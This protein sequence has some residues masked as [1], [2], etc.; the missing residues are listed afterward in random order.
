MAMSLHA[1][2]F[3]IASRTHRMKPLLVL[4]T[5]ASMLSVHPQDRNTPE[6]SPK[7]SKDLAIRGIVLEVGTDHGVPEAEVRLL[8]DSGILGVANEPVSMTNTDAHGR[9]NLQPSEFGTYLVAAQKDGYSPAEG[10]PG[11]IPPTSFV[12]VTLDKYRPKREVTVSLGRPGELTGRIVDDETDKPLTKFR[13]WICQRFYLNGQ[14]REHNYNWSTFT[15]AN[16]RFRFVGLRPSEYLVAISPRHRVIATI[17][18]KDVDAVDSEYERSYWPGGHDLISG[19]P[20]RVPSG[21]SVDVGT[22]R[23]RKTSAYRVRV[24][25]SAGECKPGETLEI[26]EIG[27]SAPETLEEAPC[28]KVFQLAGFQPGSHL[29]ALSITGRPPE[30]AVRGVAE[31]EVTDR[32]LDAQVP[33]ERGADVNGRIVAADTRTVLPFEGMR[34]TIKAVLT[35]QETAVSVGAQGSFRV[36]DAP[37]GVNRAAVTG[38]NPRFYVKQVRINGAAVVDNVFSLAAPASMEIEVD[39][40]AG[41]ITGSVSDA[42]GHAVNQPYVLLVPSSA[43]AANIFDSV[44][45]TTG[46]TSGRFQFAG[47][48][49][50]GYRVLA[51]SLA[52][53]DK[54]DEPHVLD[55]LLGSAETIAVGPTGYQNLSLKLTEPLQ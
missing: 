23:L 29:L 16:G 13:V 37:P 21:D 45:R 36:V 15:D 5:L 22:L 47:L 40:K 14:L 6:A 38:L 17:S 18:D 25:T 26:S 3:W 51:V 42:D 52:S 8:R 43:N 12:V 50:A 48:A 10:K 54:L 4:L 9:F 30:S 32:N 7:T 46:D 19:A 41:T 31:F 11:R 39:D 34:V 49:P 53:A 33:L 20:V 44:T 1:L 55:G 2:V 24:S 28:G 35:G 27:D